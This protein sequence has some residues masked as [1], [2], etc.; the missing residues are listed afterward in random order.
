M[1]VDYKE[2]DFKNPDTINNYLKII[3]ELNLSYIETIREPLKIFE[4]SQAVRSI[5]F[6]RK[7]IYLFN[8]IILPNEYPLVI[9]LYI[10]ILREFKTDLNDYLS[11][12][13]IQKNDPCELKAS[14]IF[15]VLP[16]LWSLSTRLIQLRNYYTKFK[17]N[18]LIEA[19]LDYCSDRGLLN[20]LLRNS[21]KGFDVIIKSVVGIIYNLCRS[22]IGYYDLLLNNG[23]SEILEELYET[24]DL[25]I[26]IGLA[27]VHVMKGRKLLSWKYCD[28][29]VKTLIEM[30][31]DG[32]KTPG[33]LIKDLLVV[34][35]NG[36]LVEKMHYIET[37]HGTFQIVEL[38]EALFRFAL[39]DEQKLNIF[40]EL[41][42]TNILT[43]IIENGSNYERE[44]IFKLLFQL[45]FHNDVLCS[46]KN[47]Q[48]FNDLIVKH[49]VAIK[50]C[51][52]FQWFIR[53]EISN[54][55]RKSSEKKKEIILSYAREDR[56]IY[57]CVKSFLEKS[58]YKVL[59]VGGELESLKR[60]TDEIGAYKC[61]VLCTTYNYE[62]NPFCRVVRLFTSEIYIVISRYFLLCLD[63][64]SR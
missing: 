20:N 17:A 9:N 54:K 64:N 24:T 23:A 63:C 2:S 60:I 48:K 40:S 7:N 44:S 55:E 30:I 14:I 31:Q 4:N 15:N 39:I 59:T 11:F 43:Q 37:A 34:D 52:G 38:L 22:E 28:S 3:I 33:S 18:D 47:D 10:R 62:M 1:L 32:I 12:R 29:F 8:K 42:R 16:V 61:M 53:A 5:E 58:N 41:H 56:Y 13:S 19:L 49:S 26:P 50:Y 35:Q 45:C 21:Q 36:E 27:L 6:I 25:K 51:N 46:V 57:D